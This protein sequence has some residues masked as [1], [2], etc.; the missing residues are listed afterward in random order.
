[1]QVPQVVDIGGMSDDELGKQYNT[2]RTYFTKKYI[3]PNITKQFSD[4]AKA[5][6]EDT[7]K[8]PCPL[9]ATE[10]GVLEKMKEI[11]TKLMFGDMDYTKLHDLFFPKNGKDTIILEEIVFANKGLTCNFGKRTRRKSKRTRTRTRRKS[12]RTKKRKSRRR[13]RF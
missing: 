2:Y 8:P 12:K 1:M 5:H 7:P 4:Y 3:I 10:I 11:R 9:L 13:V 6:R